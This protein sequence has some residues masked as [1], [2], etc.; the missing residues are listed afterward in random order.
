MREPMAEASRRSHPK[1]S[2]REA[3]LAR[4]ALGA[5]VLGAMLFAFPM[6]ARAQAP[7]PAP[8]ATLPGG[9]T[10]TAPGGKPQYVGAGSCGASTCH[11]SVRPRTE[12][13]ILQNE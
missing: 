3:T 5:A 4:G 10:A 6:A 9:A 7:P 11:G 13:R 12:T 2:P 1:H 8:E